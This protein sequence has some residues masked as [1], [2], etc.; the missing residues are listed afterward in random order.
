MAPSALYAKLLSL[1]QSHAIPKG[2]AAELLAIRSIDARHLWGPKYLVSKNPKL[3]ESM[4]NDSFKAHLY[5]TGPYLASSSSSKVHE[6]IVDEHKR[7]SVIHMSYFLTPK[8]SE[9]TVEQDL[10]WRLRF[11]DEGEVEG[12][13]DGVLIK[14][15]VEYIDAAASSRLG[16]VIRSLNGGVLP[17]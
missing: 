3:G 14:E 5:S 6:I 4:D 7:N 16:T 15:T 10:I 1:S 17:E 13:I 8:G 2:G 11:T 9:E 12:G